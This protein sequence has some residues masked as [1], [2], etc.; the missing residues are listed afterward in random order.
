[1]KMSGDFQLAHH[2]TS[3]QA[4]GG[5]VSVHYSFVGRSVLL[6]LLFMGFYGLGG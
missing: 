1:M 2:A 4:E 6:L 3:L 5:G